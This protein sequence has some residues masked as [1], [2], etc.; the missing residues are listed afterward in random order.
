MSASLT[1]P[2]MRVPC[3]SWESIGQCWC[4]FSMSCLGGALIWGIYII[5]TS[6][7]VIEK[8]GALNRTV[9]GVV[10][11]RTDTPP[12]YTATGWRSSR[13]SEVA[14]IY[15]R[16]QWTVPYIVFIIHCGDGIAST[17]RVTDIAVDTFRLTFICQISTGTVERSTDSINGSCYDLPQLAIVWP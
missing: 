1:K 10:T 9:A 5:L 13:C 8:T 12:R 4:A 17:V 3:T 6:L 2:K 11:W 15:E 16:R 7:P 14:L